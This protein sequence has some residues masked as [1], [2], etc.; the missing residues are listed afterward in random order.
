[1]KFDTKTGQTR[2]VTTYPS[3]KITMQSVGL[4]Q[5]G[6][7]IPLTN[8]MITKNQKVI[9]SVDVAIPIIEK[10]ID[11]KGILPDTPIP[12]FLWNKKGLSPY[13]LS[14]LGI[15]SIFGGTQAVYD[16]LVNQTLDS[17]MGAFGLPLSNEGLKTVKDQVEI[18]HFESQN[19]Y[20]KRMRDLI[21]ELKTR[22]NYSANEVKKSNKIQPVGRG[23][24]EE[25]YSSN[26]WEHAE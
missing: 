16:S 1:M 14:S 11:L 21:E 15:P 5:A 12:D 18:R 23:G 7:G 8:A 2:I 26:E 24:A 20:R 22:R 13:P 10:I 4:G 25:G 3:G 17:L 9:S 19:Q 6:D